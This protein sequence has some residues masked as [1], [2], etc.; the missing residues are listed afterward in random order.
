MIAQL[1]QKAVTANKELVD[2]LEKLSDVLG[3]T[4]NGT[5]FEGEHIR[6]THDPA[7]AT[8]NLV[9]TLEELQTK[10]DPAE[11]KQKRKPGQG[12]LR[13]R[14]KGASINVAV[15]PAI[16]PFETTYRKYK[17]AREPSLTIQK[18]VKEIVTASG[19][20][21]IVRREISAHIGQVLPA[22]MKRKANK[23]GFKQW[24]ASLGNLLRNYSA[25]GYL[26]CSVQ[27]TNRKNDLFTLGG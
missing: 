5:V 14:A 22:H 21:G 7:A 10:L 20:G 4:N 11:P 23:Q 19:S 16:W 9:K 18:Q 2:A 6:L 12:K 26:H 25:A 24:K 1:I 3:I 15:D 8:S 13:N 17:V 27:D